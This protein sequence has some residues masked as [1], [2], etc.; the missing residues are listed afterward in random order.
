M[1][2][3]QNKIIA[4]LLL[5]MI[6]TSS[7]SLV[8]PFFIKN[9]KKEARKERKV[10]KKIA[11]NEDKNGNKEPP[12]P[13]KPIEKLDENKG[14]Q[15]S[16][17]D[18]QLA[19]TLI[20]LRT[21][22][23]ETFSSKVKMHIDIGEQKQNFTANFRLQKN[24]IIWASITAF[25]I[26]VARAII[27]PDSVKAIERFN[28]KAF[29]YG[30]K[31]IEKIINLEV[32]FNTLQNLII[33]N[34]IGTDGRI[35]DVQNLGNLSTVFIVGKEFTN[36]ITFNKSDSTMKQ[37]QFQTERAVSSSSLLISFLDY[38]RN[39]NYLLSSKRELNVHDV[40]GAAQLNMEVH[41]FEFNAP[42]DFPFSIPNNYKRN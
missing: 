21:N 31:E 35:T 10:E 12:N 42:L 25:G 13:S 33:G 34:A 23:Y 22:N 40:K 1:N 32:D 39:G 36:Q 17:A 18:T 20:K 7:C 38:E 28:K 41:K 3:C 6:L 19:R 14:L 2:A 8:K 30:Y 5:L 4:T 11:K 29:L 15:F 9:R 24:K 37:I 16:K 27:T 26:E